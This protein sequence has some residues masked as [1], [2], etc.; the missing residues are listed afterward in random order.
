MAKYQDYYQKMVEDNQDLFDSFKIIHDNYLV[1]PDAWK[2]KFNNIGTE[3]MDIIKDYENRLCGKSEGS[4]YS[5][6]STGL[7]DKFWT[8]IRKNYPKID[9]IGVK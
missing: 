4:K 3:I 2:D 5:V 1:N 8:L 6:F 9:F 7:S